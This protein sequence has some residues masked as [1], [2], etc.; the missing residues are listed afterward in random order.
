MDF[1]VP[2]SSVNS[3][4]CIKNAYDSYPS[5][6][7]PWSLDIILSVFRYPYTHLIMCLFLILHAGFGILAIAHFLVVSLGSLLLSMSLLTPVLQMFLRSNL[8]Q[9]YPSSPGSC[10]IL[11]YTRGCHLVFLNSR[12]TI[13]SFHRLPIRVYTTFLISILLL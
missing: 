11:P 1:P 4:P 7:S 2:I 9:F 5:P 6:A 8:A 10:H 3:L 13:R 12:L